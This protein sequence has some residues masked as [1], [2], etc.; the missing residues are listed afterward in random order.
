MTI[1]RL[2]ARSERGFTL[3]ELMIVVAIIGILAA[4][5]YPMYLDKVREARRVAAKSLVLKAAGREEQLYGANDNQYPT[6]MQALGLPDATDDGYYTVAISQ[7]DK[8]GQTYKITA[9]ARN[10]QLAD[11]CRTLSVDQTGRRSAT[12]E[13]GADISPTC[14]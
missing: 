14:W 7:A 1:P 10:D 2:Q 3:I 9:T 13:A 12:S 5:A 8:A 6:S 11:A 4:I